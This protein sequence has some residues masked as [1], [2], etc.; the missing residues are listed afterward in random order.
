M[1]GLM[2][3]KDTGNSVKD[4]DVKQGIV[5]GYF[6]RFGNKDSDGDIIMPGAFSKTLKENGPG[7][8]KPRILH[9][10]QHETTMPLGRPHLLQ[11]LS[12]GLY[13]ESKISGTSYGRDTLKLYEDGVLTEHSIGYKVIKNEPKEEANYLHE[14]KLWEGSTVSWGANMEAVF[15][16]MKAED[17]PA[18]YDKLI[19]KL[20]AMSYAVKGN[21]TDDTIIQLELQIKQIQQLIMSLAELEKPVITTSAVAEPKNE[22]DVVSIIKQ[23]KI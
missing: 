5:C 8:P 15:T 2:L 4:V 7:S 1:K 19:K 20:E 14:L 23:F 22:I 13:F 9:L 12:D 11:E 10:L 17:K 21:Y 3:F 18:L 6:S 16:G